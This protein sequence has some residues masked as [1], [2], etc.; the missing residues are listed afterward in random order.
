[1]FFTVASFVIKNNQK[2]FKIFT[3]SVFMCEMAIRSV[4]WNGKRMWPKLITCGMFKISQRRIG[5]FRNSKLIMLNIYL[6]ID[7]SLFRAIELWIA[8][9]I[10]SIWVSQS[11]VWFWWTIGTLAGR[12]SNYN[13]GSWNFGDRNLPITCQFIS[14]SL[15]PSQNS[16]HW[17]TWWSWWQTSKKTLWQLF[18]QSLCM[19]TQKHEWC[20]C[21]KKHDEMIHFFFIE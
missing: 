9:R 12:I 18:R 11:F 16:S 15:L 10:R 17:I 13:D 5:L 4:D 7:W 2:S 19:S 20:W 8:E 3:F 21:C 14:V 1:M 6:G